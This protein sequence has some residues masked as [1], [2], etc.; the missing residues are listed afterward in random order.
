MTVGGCASIPVHGCMCQTDRQEQQNTASSSTIIQALLAV[1]PHPEHSLPDGSV[2]IP[3][4][5]AQTNGDTHTP[6]TLF[7]P[8]AKPL[9]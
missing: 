5:I 4:S 1:M 9:L 7:Y 6:Q 3:G 8:E 2:L